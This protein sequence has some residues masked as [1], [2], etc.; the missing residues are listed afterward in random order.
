MNGLIERFTSPLDTDAYLA[1]LRPTWARGRGVV[2]AVER[3]TPTATSLLIRPGRGWAGHRAGQFVTVG[4]DVGGVRHHRCYS[5]T[6]E[7]HRPD[8]RIE[9]TVQSVDGGTVSTH[10]A[11]RTRPGDDLAVG[12]A[13]GDFTL[14][15]DDRPVLAV[16]AGSGITPVMGMVRSLARG[17]R[18]ARPDVVVVHHA[19]TPDRAIFAGEL[20]R[21]DATE[22][23]LRVET[24]LTR[25]PGGGHLDGDRLARLCPDWAE[26]DAYVC[27][28]MGLLDFA[29]D[30]W[31]AAGL[32]ERL[33]LERFASSMP[34]GGVAD[35]DD[36]GDG[37]ATVR[38]AATGLDA[39]PAT[40]ATTLLDIAEANGLVPPSGCRMGICHTC[41][42]P[43]LAGCARDL[44]D[45][46][47][48]EAGTHVQ[49][50]VSAAAGDVTLDL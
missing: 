26:R 10:L 47:L 45:G 3:Q 12:S 36:L 11:H 27:G 37:D 50:C 41:S 48:V 14:L 42:T 32:V 1:A 20:A 43:L 17:G 19:P 38:F 31:A 6:S 9:I 15:D 44:R 4:V 40:P 28:P 46:R 24:V 8:G 13:E 49:L 39:V 34:T 35:S 2:E 25:E 16:T 21:L 5:L 22:P 23:W 7:P 33:H 18:R 30:H 29:T